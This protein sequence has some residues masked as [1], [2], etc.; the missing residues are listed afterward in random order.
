MPYAK[1]KKKK[2]KL[3]KS[4]PK[5]TRKRESFMKKSVQGVSSV[6]LPSALNPHFCFSICNFSITNKR[7]CLP[8]EILT[9]LKTC[10]ETKSLPSLEVL[11]MVNNGTTNEKQGSAC[12]FI[13]YYYY[14]GKLFIVILLNVFV[15]GSSESQ[16][17]E[18]SSWYIQEAG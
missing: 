16:L 10:K 18:N 12:S 11:Q 9:M 4:E 7:G 13:I 5:F 14:S 6:H 3:E 17:T 2:E 8:S 15:V 1:N